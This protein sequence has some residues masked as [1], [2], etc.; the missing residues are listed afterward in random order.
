[1][2]RHGFP[3]F[4]LIAA[5]LALL[6]GCATGSKTPRSARIQKVLPSLLDLEGRSSLHPSLYERDAY[7]AWLRK[8]P[9]EVGGL[10]FDVQWKAAFVPGKPV[11]IRLELRGATTSTNSAASATTPA[12]TVQLTRQIAPR[13][14]LS[15]WTAFTLDRATRD[16]VG[17][18]SAWRA[19]LWQDGRELTSLESF[20]W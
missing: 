20:L 9:E 6:A 16:Q 19:S 13:A 2:R 12:G 17:D 4:I 1:M 7:Q 11:Q 14:L 15:Q 5:L 3:H 8:R 18:V 10:R